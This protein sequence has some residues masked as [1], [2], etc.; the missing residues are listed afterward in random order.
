M[1]HG[2]P[3]TQDLGP[4]CL[5]SSCALRLANSNTCSPL[6]F[7]AHPSSSNFLYLLRQRNLSSLEPPPQSPRAPL[8]FTPA[9]SRLCPSALRLVCVLLAL[10]TPALASREDMIRSL[11]GADTRHA[12]LLMGSGFEAGKPT[13]CFEAR[14]RGWD[15]QQ[16]GVAAA[17][18][19]RSSREPAGGGAWSHV[20]RRSVCLFRQGRDR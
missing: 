3:P 18:L 13:C 6:S 1:S 15:R 4:G 20:S 7:P 14:R 2:R 17:A 12:Q 5:G 16:A 19:P 9:M 10:A 11:N 8:V